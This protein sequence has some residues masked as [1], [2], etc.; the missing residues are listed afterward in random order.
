MLDHDQRTST[1]PDGR[2]WWA[3]GAAIWAL[4]FAI[5]GVYWATGGT[6]GLGT[7]SQGIRDAAATGDPELYAALWITVVLEVVGIFLA[8]GLAH[9]G[10][11]RL[12]RAALALTGSGAG[13]VLAAHGAL[14]IGFGLAA[15]LRGQPVSIELRWYALL[16]GPWF[17]LG[18]ILFLLAVR[19]YAEGGDLLT[20]LGRMAGILGGLTAAAA[21]YVVSALAGS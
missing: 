13:T 12:T 14:F 20:R 15:V 4:F 17:L 9:V 8:L 1:G 10:R 19:A 6:V 21:P 5:R 3:Y 11:R 7:L 16:W 2:P 18:G